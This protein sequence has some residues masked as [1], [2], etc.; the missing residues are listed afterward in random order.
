VKNPIELPIPKLSVNDLT[1]NK[2]HLKVLGIISEH[3]R[4]NQTELR[5][6]IQTNPNNNKELSPQ[7]LSQS[8]HYLKKYELINME[9]EGRDTKIEST[10]SGKL[11]YS[12]IL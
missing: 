5:N 2:L 3:E 12:M 11:A 10:L 1:K 9:H 6:K 7:T 8:L 4:I